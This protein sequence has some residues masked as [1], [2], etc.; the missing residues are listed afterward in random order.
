MLFMQKIVAVK[1]HAPAK[2]FMNA[3]FS[4]ATKH[5]AGEN[6]LLNSPSM[7][8]CAGRTLYLYI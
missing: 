6:S 1:A 7:R 5:Y 2:C 8:Q 4:V 3:K